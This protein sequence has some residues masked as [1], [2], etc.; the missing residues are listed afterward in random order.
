MNRSTSRTTRPAIAAT[1][2]VLLLA[3]A[4]C[5]D[6]TEPTATDPAAGETSTGPAV[7]TEPTTTAPTTPTESTAPTRPPVVL[8]DCDEVWAGETLPFG[9]RGCLEGDTVVEAMAY[10]CSSGGRLIAYRNHYA[11]AGRVI[12]DTDGP[13]TEDRAY[14][15][16]IQGCSA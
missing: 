14:G 1:A 3:L 10:P 5:G 15:R 11:I 8:P 6:D 7:P 13:A 9:Y 2:F 4:G 12:N 16:A